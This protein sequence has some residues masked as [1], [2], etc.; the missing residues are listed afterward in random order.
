MRDN[1]IKLGALI[2]EM[3]TDGIYFKPPQGMKDMDG[4]EAS[5]QAML[6]PGIEV[7]L[8]ACYEAMF[9]YKAKNYALLAEDGKISIA[10]AALKSRGLEPFQRRFVSE[11]VSLLLHG[12][13]NELDDL[14]SRYVLRNDMRSFC[15]Y[16]NCQH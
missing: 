6:P 2:V 8:D 1:L 15:S 16:L 5:V 13:E 12:R 4:M 9:S 11:Y 7:D 10:G 14:Y 3:D